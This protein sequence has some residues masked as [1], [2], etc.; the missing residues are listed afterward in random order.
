MKSALNDLYDDDD[1]EDVA[2][3]CDNPTRSLL[4]L[5]QALDEPL[6]EVS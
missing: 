5:S 3:Y 2:V 1:D 4:D 6:E